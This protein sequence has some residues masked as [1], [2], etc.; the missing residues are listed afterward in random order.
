MSDDKEPKSP[1]AQ[2]NRAVV[3]RS[4]NVT[5]N[6]EYVDG[7]GGNEEED[8]YIFECRVCGHTAEFDANEPSERNEARDNFMEH[9]REEHEGFVRYELKEA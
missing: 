2:A 5:S 7:T 4:G 1:I 6:V 8:P 3:E 9:A